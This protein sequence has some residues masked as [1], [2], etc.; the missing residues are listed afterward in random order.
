MCTACFRNR[1][2]EFNP[3]SVFMCFVWLSKWTPIHSKPPPQ[4]VKLWPTFF[5]CEIEFAYYIWSWA[6][7]GLDAEMDSHL[8][9]KL[10][11]DSAFKGLC[12]LQGSCFLVL[13]THCSCVNQWID[14]V[15]DESGN[16]CDSRTL[17]SQKIRGVTEVESGNWW[18]H[19]SYLSHWFSRVNE[20]ETRNLFQ[21]WD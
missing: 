2:S 3:Y 14:G 15:V 16:Q 12:H 21:S 5:S 17:L 8:Q 11:L 4:S 9:S 18:S 20:A 7:K 1:L 6:Q 19:C 10:I 13:H